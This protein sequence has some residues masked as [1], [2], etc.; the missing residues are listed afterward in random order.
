MP[1]KRGTGAAARPG[2]SGKMA[3]YYTAL[4]RAI[5]KLDRE[6]AEARRDFYDH[7]REVLNRRLIASD[8]PPEASEVSR[9]RQELEK[10]I[11]RVEREIAAG[12]ESLRPERPQDHR[13]ETG[14]SGLA[15]RLVPESRYDRPPAFTARAPEPTSDQGGRPGTPE[16]RRPDGSKE[17]KAR[18]SESLPRRASLPA[19]LLLALTVG[20]VIGLGLLAWSQRTVIVDLF[21]GSDSEPADVVV[22]EPAPLPPD[23]AGAPTADAAAPSPPATEAPAAAGPKALLIEAQPETVAAAGDTVIG[24]TVDWQFVEDGTGGGEIRADL[25][26]PARGMK[27]SLVIR[28]NADP[29]LPATHLVEVVTDTPADFPGK[30]IRSVPGLALKPSERQPAEPLAA[31]ATPVTGGIFWIALSATEPEVTRN[32]WLLRERPWID[33]PLVYETGQRAI[34]TF[35]KSQEGAEAFDSA[36]AIWNSG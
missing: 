1:P 10:A 17:A 29:G 19:I 21:S 32:L 6:S 18:W 20:A 27:V 24:A 14:R 31:A 23:T 26:V 7:A 5:E 9:Q 2:Q 16:R 13:A 28:R 25:E 22:P 15:G 4:K 36:F 33:L 35:E 12:A 30:G 8:P 11:R 34:L 3:D